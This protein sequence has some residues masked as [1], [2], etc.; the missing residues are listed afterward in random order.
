[1]RP[2]TT[3]KGQREP[4]SFAFALGGTWDDLPGKIMTR[5]EGLLDRVMYYLPFDPGEMDDRWRG[6]IEA[7]K[8]ATAS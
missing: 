5:Y 2:R 7:F 8:S 3:P 6:I 4:V 1:M